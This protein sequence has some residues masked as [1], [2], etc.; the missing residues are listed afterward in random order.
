MVKDPS[1]LLNPLTNPIFEPVLLRTAILFIAGLFLIVALN[2]GFDGL[3]D[4]NLWRRYVS[5]LLIA[6]FYLTAVFLGGT[7]SLFFLLAVILVAVWEYKEISGLPQMYTW[8]L[9]VLS[10]VSVY[11]ASYQTTLFYSLPVLYFTTLTTIGIRTNT[12]TAYQ[13][14]AE[15]LFFMIWVVFSMSHFVLL[16]HLNNTFDFTKSLLVLLGFAVPL[17]DIGAYVIGKLSHKYDVL[18]W[19]IA[20]NVSPNK[21]YGGVIGNIL[22]AGL[23]I[24]VM[25]F[26]IRTYL[27][28]WAWVLMAFLFGVNGVIGDLTE[29][30]MKRF[31]DV[32][33]SSSLIPGHGGVL[34]RIDSTL[35]VIIVLFYT[36]Q[37]IL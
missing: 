36:L 16:G 12:K 22:G 6:P 1:W 20:E 37:L 13:R 18:A 27:P 5:W 32:K 35:R 17:S 28:V 29:S 15:T 10:V 4:S 3:T 7:V 31:Y 33:D 11:V 9:Y 23:G 25:W 26:A 24:A 8:T 34:D 14:T 30:T 19:P 21:T 2:K